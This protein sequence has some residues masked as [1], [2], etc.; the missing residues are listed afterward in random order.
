[1]GL[2]IMQRVRYC[3]LEQ[4]NEHFI[5]EW[6]VQYATDVTPVRHIFL[7]ALSAV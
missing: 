6:C 3:L 7:L 5:R 1:M 2:V 4:M